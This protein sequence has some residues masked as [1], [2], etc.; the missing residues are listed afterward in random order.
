MTERIEI[1]KLPRI[2]LLNLIKDLTIEQLNKV[3]EGFNNNIIWNLGHIVVAQQNICYKRAG[4]TPVIDESLFA[5]Y[6]PES[7]PEKFIDAAELETIKELFIST[8][9]RLETDLE[10]NIFTNY[11]PWITR[12]NFE[13]KSINDAVAF[14][15]FH[16]GLH[17]GYIM[18]LKRVAVK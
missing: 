18:A 4:L 7:K 3:P 13:M 17:A 10:N 2:S 8:I 12:Y 5:L 1:I 14:L 9:D 15:P 16:E 11:T 6:K